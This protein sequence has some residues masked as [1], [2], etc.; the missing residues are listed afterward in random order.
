MNLAL[1]QFRKDVRQFRVLL[2]VWFGL[3]ALDLAVNLG[4]AGQVV[5][6]PVRGFDHAANT[7]TG[8][9]PKVIWAFVAVLPSLVVLT[10][11]P[12]R[13]EGFLA[14]RP[15]PKGDLFLAKMLF[16]LAL[17]VAPWVLQELVHLAMSGMPG[18]VVRR[19]T[20]ERLMYTLPVA[21]GFGAYA[22][23]WPGHARWARAIG[24][25][26]V[27][28]YLLLAITALVSHFIFHAEIF[29]GGS[30]LTKEMAGVYVLALAL[31]VLAVWHSRA[32]RG[33]LVRWSGLALV[34]AGYWLTT[35]YCP[36][37][38]FALQPEN[39]PAA[40]SVLA[41]SGFEIPPRTLRLQKVQDMDDAGQPHFNLSLEPKIQSLPTNDLIE[42][43]G[44]DA[45]LVRAGGTELQG[46]KIDQT[47]IFNGNYW[48]YTYNTPDFVAWSA[49][50][51]ADVLFC[52]NGYGVSGSDALGFYQFKLPADR[53]AL[54]EP[55]TLRASF[56]ARVFQWRKIADLPLT[57]GATAT[58][59][60]GS[61]K[62]IATKS[63]IPPGTQLFLQRRQIELATATGSRCSSAEY[64][65][66]T[67]MAFMV[68][69]PL[70]HVAWLADNT[71]FNNVT[72]GTDTALAQYFN[73]LVFSAR[74]PFAPE[75]IAR[76]RLIIFE[77]SWL[78][79]VPETWSSPA[80]TLDEKLQP[81]NF[82]FAGN[83]DPM[84][85]TEFNRRIAALKA[86]APDAPRREVSLYLLEFLR[87]VDARRFPLDEN[88][89]Q[90]RQLAAFVPAQL[91]LLLDGLPV[92]N[93]ASRDAVITAI[94]LGVTDA[95]KPAILAALQREPEL[96]VVLFA[97][98]W[99][100]DARP[101]I[102]QLVQS[103]SPQ[104]LPQPA[105]Q[106]IAWFH[107]PQTYPRLLEEFE[108]DPTVAADDLLR[109]LPGL[110]APLESIVARQWHE[111]SLVFRHNNIWQMFGQTFQLAL[112]HGQAGAL[113][114]AYV[115][116]DDPDFEQFN[117]DYTL[118]YA[119]A[120][121]IQMPGVRPQDRQKSEVVL[122][123]MRQ[124]RPEDFIFNPALRQFVL[125]PN[126]AAVQTARNP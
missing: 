73:T 107:D 88:G 124:H 21:A 11:S 119:L 109:T 104:R 52:Q 77:K 69:D 18:W 38:F 27:G 123:W 16:I 26:V 90:L 84:P 78:G 99:V 100:E 13:R 36:W 67:R 96:A 3:L 37:N 79:S 74:K 42:W 115:F 55:L 48:N 126:P 93:G 53:E 106:A 32:H 6:S 116:L 58:D 63:S 97:R 10:D 80:F 50:F 35:A 17:V 81:V 72:R 92:M 70:R 125:Q 4:W 57:P 101:E 23:L 14:T 71:G 29:P 41:A 31:L 98:G 7:W 94:K 40:D 56:E 47:K 103:T 45:K 28:G 44:R 34:A 12:A 122:A 83:N 33:G 87:L 117:L 112:R 68:Y 113:Q 120:D 102:Y 61:W 89:P 19:G 24:V 59:E 9:L 95:Q 51:P 39:Q 20:L 76:C 62:F 2:A 30:N 82:G 60:Y 65:A 121:G 110:D 85:R 43:S 105:L 22:A 66:L 91:D 46:G 15:L 111:E 8:L 25:T 64:G 5:Y 75:E 1:H 118:A 86:P 114:R 108:A 54:A 49:E